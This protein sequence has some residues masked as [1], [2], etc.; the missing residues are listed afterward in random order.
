MAQELAVIAGGGVAA[1]ANALIP[2]FEKD[3]GAK[4]KMTYTSGG[5]MAERVIK[6]EQYDAG[7]VPSEALKPLQDQKKLDE[8]TRAHFAEARFAFAVKK[9]APP[10][11]AATLELFQALLTDARSIAWPD[12]KNG[13]SVG[14]MFQKAIDLWTPSWGIGEDLAKKTILAKEL[15]DIAGLLKSGKAQY[16]VLLTTQ[17]AADPELEIASLMPAEL[18]LT[19]AYIGYV[20]ADARQPDL[21]RKFIAHMTTP[22]AADVVRAMGFEQKK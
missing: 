3:T 7:L 16:G 20:M 2:G 9:G 8:A 17:I 1:A 10:V 14:I 13:A 22:A 5:A 4:V 15:R 19:N 6:G 12:P 18:Q 11:R 21:A